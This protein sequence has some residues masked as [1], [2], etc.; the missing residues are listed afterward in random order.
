MLEVPIA[1]IA[2]NRPD[3][4]GRTL[5]SI[6]AAAPRQLFL[7]LDGPRD[8][9]PDDIA[10][11]A[12][13]R[14]VLE[15]IDWPCEVHRRY[16]DVNLGC[17]ANV[18][19]G[20][21][22]VFSQVGSAIVLEDDCVPDPS[23]FTYAA[24][25]LERYRD[26]EKV[27]HVAGNRHFVPSELFG[28]DSYRFSTWASVWGW[29]TWADRWQAH[30]AWFPRSHR[31]DDHRP[32]R[33]RPAVPAPGSLVTSA[34]RRHF[35][36]AADS[37]DLITHGWD[38]HWWITIAAADGLSA[39]PRPNLVENIGFG[40]D[41]THTAEADHY[42]EPAVPVTFPLHHP[43]SVARDVEIERELELLLNRVGG[44]AAVL[45]RK[46]VSSPRLR[47]ALRQ[48]AH[49]DLAQRTSRR[50]SRARGQA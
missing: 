9:R 28:E 24:E 27:W 21:D 20:L 3:V 47:A 48:M 7:I 50:L 40:A 44:R 1:L 25:L 6:R 18:E 36:E 14:E 11:C 13:V 33:S 42:G 10:G 15:Q 38:K 29:A 17:D 35:V 43:A 30:R 34:T 37:D 49:S 45:A 26:D 39:T 22:W 12:G 41:A 23:F 31:E 4:T 19:T 2:F 5:A 8:G 32:T 16:S 46:L